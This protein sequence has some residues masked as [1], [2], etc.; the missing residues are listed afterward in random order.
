MEHFG[1]TYLFVTLPLVIYGICRFEMLSSFGEYAD[2][3]DL[4]LRDRPFQMTVV[5]CGP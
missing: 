3:T 4:I 2:P 1:T 5:L